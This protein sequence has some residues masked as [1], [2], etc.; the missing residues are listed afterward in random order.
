MPELSV[1]RKVGPLEP[2][3]RAEYENFRGHGDQAFG[4]LTFAQTGED[5]IIANLFNQMGKRRPS[6]LDIG[7]HHP[8]RISNTALLYLRGSRGVNVEANPH[9]IGE[10]IR[11]RPGDVNVNIGVSDVAGEM[12]FYMIDE[13]SGR[14]TFDQTVA[15]AYVREHPKR[16]IR[17]RMS[18]KVT[19]INTLVE[20]HCGGVFP[21]LLTIDVEGFDLRILKS[22]NF[23]SSKPTVIST[24]AKAATDFTGVGLSPFLQSKG[25][26]MVFRTHSN[27]IFLGERA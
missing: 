5:L 19:T 24:E 16:S 10:F 17:H 9:L 8:I 25:Y 3:I 6:Y 14:N 26:S 15:E 21:D 7:A 1:H 11:L 27:A 22:A 2:D 23:E 20:E 18:L 12:T 4:G 13:Y